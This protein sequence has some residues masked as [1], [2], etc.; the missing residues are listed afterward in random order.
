MAIKKCLG[1]RRYINNKTESAPSDA[2]LQTLPAIESYSS[3]SFLVYS[4]WHCYE[5]LKT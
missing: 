1:T 2:V 3:F 5:E 4:E